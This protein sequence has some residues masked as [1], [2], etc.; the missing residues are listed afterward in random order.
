MLSCGH[1]CKGVENERRCLPCLDRDCIKE[2][3]AKLAGVSSGDELC[4]ICFTSELNSE[5]CSRLSCG[6]VFHTNCVVQLLKHKWST[7]RINFSFMS[8]PS[9]KKEIEFK[10]LSKPIAKELRPLRSLKHKVETEALFNAK[11]QRVLKDKRLTTKGD[12]Y[13]N[14]PKEFAMHK[15][16]FYECFRCKSPYFG[17]LI[18]C[19]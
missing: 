13:Y 11:R 3:G 8:C 16:T 14:K 6:H 17:G 10:G 5:A 1:T 12:A 2:S 19:Q 4:A 18:D 15:C 9:C 7:L